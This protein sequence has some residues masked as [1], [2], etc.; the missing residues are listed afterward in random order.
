[1]SHISMTRDW[2]IYLWYLSRRWYHP[3]S[4]QCFG[5]TW[6]IWSMHYCNL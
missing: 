4:S 2:Y 3:P 1:L 5:L 6:I